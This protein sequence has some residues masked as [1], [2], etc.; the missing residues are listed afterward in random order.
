MPTLHSENTDTKPGKFRIL[1]PDQKRGVG[2][3]VWGVGCG[4]RS[5]NH[6]LG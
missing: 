1:T 5:K 3:G 6:T 4:E 2:C